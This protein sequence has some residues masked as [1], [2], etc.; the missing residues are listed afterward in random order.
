CPD[1]WTSMEDN[2]YRVFPG[3]TS[4]ETA[5]ENCMEQGF[6]AHLAS[7]N[8]IEEQEFVEGQIEIYQQDAWIGLNCRREHALFEWTNGERLMYTNWAT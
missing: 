6:A 7:V 1:H 8:N 2:C 3:E 5:E 4:W